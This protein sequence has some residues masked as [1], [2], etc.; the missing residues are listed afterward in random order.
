M[1][2]A[3]FTLA[4][5]VMAFG[6]VGFA[7]QR[8]V[9]LR[10]DA[11]KNVLKHYGVRDETTVVPQEA[12]W[13]D[14]YGTN[15]RTD[16]FYDEYDFYLTEEVSQTNDGE[17]WYNTS[18]IQYEYGF[19]GNVIEMLG[20]EW[21]VNDW[22]DIVMA[23]FTYEGDLIS[24]AIYQVNLGSG[25][26]NYMKEV[27]DY[28]GDQSTVLYYEWNGTT[29]STLELY[30]YT[31]GNGTIE[32]VIQYMQGGA[33]QNDERQL[34]TL[35]FDEKVE[36]VVVQKWNGSSWDNYERT[37]YVYEDGVFTSK[38]I[39]VWTAED[40]ESQYHFVYDYDGNGNA[41]LGECSYFDGENWGPDDNDI[42]MAYGYS[43]NSNDYYGWRV[44]VE[45][46]DLTGV[47]EN[48]QAGSFLVYPVPAQDEIYIEAEGFQKAEIYSLTGQKLVESLRDKMNVSTLS[49]G[50]YVMKVYDR[51]GGCVTQRFVVK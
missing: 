7:Q 17:G 44:E 42:E 20:Q 45:Y 32:L 27:Y 34:I 19:S 1:K 41:I 23:S 22:V 5:L 14:T 12:R 11:T 47:N 43:A 15:Y 21:D 37:T 8:K 26:E 51:E 29:W 4:V 33:W 36:E 16:Y 31:Y 3:I 35:N 24:E 13:Q 6:N 28:N 18:R 10:S 38:D 48:S 49:S 25:W 39:N 40:W 9:D 50:I 46:V 2:K 30:T